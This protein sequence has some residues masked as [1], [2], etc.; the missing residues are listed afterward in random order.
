MTIKLYI[1]D[2]SGTL[3]DDRRPVYEANMRVLERYGKPRMIFEEWLPRTTM[4]PI[5]FFN[6]HGVF[7]NPD[8]L[9]SLYLT[10][11]KEVNENGILPSVYPGSGETLRTLRGRG[12]KTAVISSH[13]EEKIHEEA[14]R[15]GVGDLFDEIVGNVRNKVRALR[16]MRERFR[17]DARETIYIGDTIYDIR[18]G[19]E[20][21][22]KVAVVGHG[23]HLPERLEQENP[24]YLLDNLRILLDLD[25]AI[26][27]N[28]NQSK[29]RKR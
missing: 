24:D 13:P 29:E 17:T 6:N 18:A 8:E 16:E 27:G 4:T 9:F 15:Y 25:L 11:F 21:G 1:F 10:H 7:G 12:K 20:A 14:G 23:Y 3:S 2:W 5:E 22:I 28:L 26:E 19:R